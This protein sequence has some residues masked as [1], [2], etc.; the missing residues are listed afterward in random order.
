MPGY[1]NSGT[2]EYDV[3]AG[4]NLISSFKKYDKVNICGKTEINVYCMNGGKRMV[5]MELS[6]PSSQVTDLRHLDAYKNVQI[7]TY[8]L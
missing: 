5:I 3:G 2:L 6:A 1:L 4:R 7:K 8:K